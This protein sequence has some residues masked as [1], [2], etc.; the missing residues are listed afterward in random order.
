M[1]FFTAKC[2]GCN[3]VVAA[4]VDKPEYAKESGED[5]VAWIKRELWV[6]HITTDNKWIIVNKCQCPLRR[7][8]KKK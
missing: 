3:V 2:R 1:E 8:L 7:K 6:E 4:C 5:V